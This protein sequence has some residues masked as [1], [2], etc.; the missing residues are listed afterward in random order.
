MG[1]LGIYSSKLFHKYTGQ[2]NV[3][4]DLLK[5]YLDIYGSLDVPFLFTIGS[6]RIV[7]W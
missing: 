3:K 5:A 7:L 6:I 2:L 1:G 4:G